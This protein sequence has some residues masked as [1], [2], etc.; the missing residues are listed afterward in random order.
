M[1]LSVAM[2]TYNGAR[3]LEEQLES[4][5]TQSRLPDEVVICDDK[6]SD[7]TPRLIRAFSERVS[8]PVRV[9]D[10]PRNLGYRQNFEQCIEMCGGEVIALCD[11]DD[12]WR[13]DKLQR[14]ERALAENPRAGFAFSDAEII[15]ESSRPTGERLWQISNLTPPRREQLKTA[16]AAE[17]LLTHN[18]VTGATMAFRASFKPLVL[19]FAHGGPIIHDWWIALAIAAVAEV[20]LVDEPLVCYRRHS[21]Q[22]MGFRTDR[23]KV[24]GK[25]HYAALQQQLTELATRLRAHGDARPGQVAAIRG[26]AAHL[27]TRSS[28]PG[29]QPLRL[30]G[31]LK[32][33]ITGRYHRFSNGFSSAGRDLIF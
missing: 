28:L 20:A 16:R 8:F 30:P 7:A 4:I 33:L 13:P 29:F 17:V 3:F 32:E 14:L 31:V 10:N 12:V 2:C 23:D 6:S 5:E 26:K 19:P 27:A 22:S 11:Q 9:H 15:D 1:K 24:L 18:A 21:A 25:E